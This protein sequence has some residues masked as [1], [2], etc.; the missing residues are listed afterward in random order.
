VEKSDFKKI[1][2]LHLNKHSSK[3]LR[4]GEPSSPFNL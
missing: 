4:T 1:I 2:I 3:E